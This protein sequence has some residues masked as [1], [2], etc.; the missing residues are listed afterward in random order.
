MF[1]PLLKI[2]VAFQNAGV[3]PD[4][5]GVTGI[6]DR[7]GTGLKLQFVL[8]CSLMTPPSEEEGRRE[9]QGSGISQ[10]LKEPMFCPTVNVYEAHLS[11]HPLFCNVPVLLIS[12]PPVLSGPL[13]GCLLQS[14]N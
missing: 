1:V 8:E 6:L 4:V 5:L 9:R 14:L 12:F 10:E 11:A 13:T 2:T 3:F 7:T